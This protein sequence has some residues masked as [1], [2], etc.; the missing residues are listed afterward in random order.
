MCVCECVRVCGREIFR[1]NHLKS[2][3]YSAKISTVKKKKKQK[4]KNKTNKK[5]KNK[6]KLILHIRSSS[7][8]ISTCLKFTQTVFF[9]VDNFIL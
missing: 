1:K 8:L 2:V 7:A 9:R 5:K 6:V 3:K 4:N